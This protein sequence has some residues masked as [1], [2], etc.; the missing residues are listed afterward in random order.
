V[1]LHPQRHLQFLPGILFIGASQHVRREHVEDLGPKWLGVLLDD[2]VT[3]EMH[4][5]SPRGSSN[6]YFRL[7]FRPILLQYCNKGE[8]ERLV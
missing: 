4:L 2:W 6:S 5:H 3:R 7:I 8:L 1:F